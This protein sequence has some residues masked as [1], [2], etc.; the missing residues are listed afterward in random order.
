MNGVRAAMSI[1]SMRGKGLPSQSRDELYRLRA[2]LRRR[3][4]PKRCAA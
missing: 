4:L 3:P 2:L 1:T